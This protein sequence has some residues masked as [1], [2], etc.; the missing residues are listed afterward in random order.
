V[1]VGV[2]R[3]YLVKLKYYEGLTAQRGTKKR[4]DDALTCLGREFVEFNSFNTR[5]NARNHL[6]C[7]DNNEFVQ[8]LFI[9]HIVG[10]RQIVLT[11]RVMATGST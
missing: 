2:N 8:T 7:K 3:I 5:V 9:S 11:L 10:K 1:C 6:I 4:K